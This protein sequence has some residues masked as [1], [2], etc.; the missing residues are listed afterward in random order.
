MRYRFYQRIML[1]GVLFLGSLF[2]NDAVRIGITA[3]FHE[4]AAIFFASI[5]SYIF[6]VLLVSV[7]V[8]TVVWHNRKEFILPFVL[9]FI[10]AL[11]IGMVLKSIIALDRPFLTFSLSIII[12]EPGYSFPSL[13]TIASF[14]LL[15]IIWYK[16]RG[17]AI[18]WFFFSLLIA[19]SRIYLGVHYFSD[20][21]AGACIGYEVASFFIYLE[22]KYGI[23]S[24]LNRLFI[25][26]LEIR[27][28]VFHLLFGC[29]LVFLFKFYLLTTDTLFLLIVLMLIMIYFLRRYHRPSFLHQTLSFFEREKHIARF[30]AR[31]ILFFTI[32]SFLSFLLFPDAIALAS[33]IVLSLGDSVT[34][35]VGRYFG[36]LEIFYN[37]KKH[38]EGTIAGIFFATLGAS[39]FLPLWVAFVSATG[40]LLIETCDF[41]FL[42]IEIDDNLTI[43]LITGG[44]ASLLMLL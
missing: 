2:L 39:F 6:I 28:Q 24:H 29:L 20:V 27:R 33:I 3:I 18:F 19:F 12:T 22:Q 17:V 30:P 26:T 34:N 15:P 37:P 1:W 23:F 7:A 42:G 32:G 43:P 40:A 8:E 16:N 25:T 36:K 13:H 21:V 35:V 9:S 11:W 31:G 14:S 5:C 38:W 44:I 4:N 41:S 10:V